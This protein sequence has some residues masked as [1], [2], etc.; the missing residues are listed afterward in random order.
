MLP[1]SIDGE[2][3]MKKCVLTLSAMLLLAVPP[4]VSAQGFGLAA[5]AG[6]LGVGP[7]AALGLTDAFVIRGGI[8][9]T[10]FDPSVTIDDIAFT[11]TLP[12]RWVTIGADIYLGGTFRIGG[13]MLFKSENPMLA[14]EI[15][16]SVDIGDMTYTST[17]VSQ[18]NGTLDSKEQAPYVLIGFGKHTS[19]GIGLFIDVGAAFLGE[20]DVSLEATG[21]PAIIDSAEFQAELRRQETNIEE[22]LGSYINVWPI[23]S[24][25]LRIGVGG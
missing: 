21:D 8:G 22:D 11:L 3:L 14:G 7:E 9:L 25:G 4:A 24:I 1:V 12:D 15:T 10:T 23:L 18:L 5:R 13:G 16:G 19:S 6:T 2:K 17:E 20:S